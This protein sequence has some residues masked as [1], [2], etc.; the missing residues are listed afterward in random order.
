MIFLTSVA[1][2]TIAHSLCCILWHSFSLV[3]FFFKYILLIML[4][5]LS[6]FP[7][8]FSSALHTPSHPH[9]LPLVHVHG[10]YICF[11][12]SPFPILFLTSPCLFLP[13]IYI[14]YSLYLS[15]FLPLL[16]PNDNPPCDLHF[17]DSVPALVVFL[18]CFLFFNFLLSFFWL[19]EEAQCVY[20]CL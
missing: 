4:L 8:L 11:L 9:S 6:H 16:L 3:F 18:V 19:C 5:Q 2:D 15:P 12:A 20:L 7:P 17:Y 1:S 10:L 13:H 14:T